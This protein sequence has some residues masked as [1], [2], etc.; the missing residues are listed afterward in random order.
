MRPEVRGD[1]AIAVELLALVADHP[2]TSHA[3]RE[4]VKELLRELEAELP[5][6]VFGRVTAQGRA[7]ELEDV[8]AQLLRAGDEP[9]RSY[10]PSAMPTTRPNSAPS[11]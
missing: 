1:I 4:R 6:E 9:G 7:R 10:Q 8:I 3:T 2:F 5:P 11:G